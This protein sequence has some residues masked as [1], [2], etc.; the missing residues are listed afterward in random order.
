MMQFYKLISAKLGITELDAAL[1]DLETLLPEL[2]LYFKDVKS[3]LEQG[4]PL[5]YLLP[6]TNILGL[7]L[8]LNQSILIPRPETVEWL[9]DLVNSKFLDFK[10]LVTSSNLVVDLG[11]GSGLIGLYLSRY[12]R[13]VLCLDISSEAVGVAN[14]NAI[15]NN[16]T[17]IEFQISNGLDYFINQ[18]FSSSWVLAANLPYV[19]IGDLVNAKDYQVEYEPEIAIYSG[20][21]GLDLFRIVLDQLKEMSELPIVVIFELDPRNIQEAKNL[22]ETKFGTVYKN[23]IWNDG[24]G[25]ERVLIGILE[26]S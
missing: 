10:K 19:S 20:E 13:Q 23:K 17:N 15:A 18:N 5:D 12:F 6:K 16:I 11:C 25:L 2:Q 9:T 22:I 21:D 3:K 4:Y 24:A 1:L 7:D 26:Q 8:V 14:Q